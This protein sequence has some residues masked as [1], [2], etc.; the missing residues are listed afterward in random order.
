[1]LILGEDPKASL[2]KTQT[3]IITLQNVFNL[4][5]F[6]TTLVISKSLL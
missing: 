2:A 1:M 5:D 4:F 6:D 3:E